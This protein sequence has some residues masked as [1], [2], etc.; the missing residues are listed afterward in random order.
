[1]TCCGSYIQR[2]ARLAFM[3]SA[4]WCAVSAPSAEALDRKPTEQQVKAAYLY[5]FAKFVE[6]PAGPLSDPSDT[7]VFGILGDDPFGTDIDA[8]AGK[9]VN[10]KKT[11]VRR[12]RDVSEIRT[13]HVLFISASE[14]GK[15]G[16]ILQ[17]LGSIGTLLVSDMKNFAVRGGMIGF[18]ITDGTVGFEVNLS[19]VARAGLTVHSRLLNMSVI[20]QEELSSQEE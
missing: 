7:I 6:W 13:C 10:G 9:S 4:F 12:Y 14:R 16:K 5:N 18:I 8:V 17:D 19:A 20:V 15:F 2:V 11:Q 3:V 1:M